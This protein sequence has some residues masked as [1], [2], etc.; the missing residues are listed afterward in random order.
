[1]AKTKGII[2]GAAVPHAP[3]F[4]TLP[5]T[6]DRDQVQR[7]RE[8]MQEVGDG[9]RALSPDVIVVM[10]NDHGD[11][12]IVG[13]TPQFAV[14]C[15]N[16]ANGLF[17]HKGSW[18]LRGDIGYQVVRGLMEENF[19][20]AFTLD[21]IVP[22]AFTIP[23]EFMGYERET[24][25]LPIYIN[26][27]VPP[28]PSAQRCYAFGQALDRVFR[29]LGLS[30]V[31]VGSGGLSHF[32]G[33]PQYPHPDVQTDKVIYEHMS[34][35]NLRHLLTYSDEALDATGNVEARSL[36]SLA[37]AIGER[38]PDITAWEPSWH[39]TYAVFGWTKEPAAP[40]GKPHY[41]EIPPQHAGLARAIFEMRKSEDACR[42]YLRDRAAYATSYGLSEDETDAFVTFDQDRLRDQF[43]IHALL[44]AGAGRRIGSLEKTKST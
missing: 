41:P 19:D 43:D 35:G 13:P 24:P 6:E 8:A 18:P 21:S 44:I 34:K 39:H 42:L 12:F 10:T 22:N 29:N 9:L 33:T 5:D 4:H 3:Q 27:Y 30:A 28:Q 38:T 31:F 1:M 40:L 7:V 37:G 17:R 11:E 23:L 25:F 15:G 26:S 32:P 2:G 16:T 14:H 20:P 36:I